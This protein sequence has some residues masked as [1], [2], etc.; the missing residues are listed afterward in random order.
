MSSGTFS[1]APH[2]TEPSRESGG[3]YALPELPTME[4]EGVREGVSE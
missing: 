4:C 2:P 3:V 1:R